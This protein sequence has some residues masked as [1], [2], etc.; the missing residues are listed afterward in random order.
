MFNFCK[1]SQY[2][3]KEKIEKNYQSIDFRYTGLPSTA[4]R[5][6]KYSL[7]QEFLIDKHCHHVACYLEMQGRIK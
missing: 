6:T 1:L 2:T 4:L 5:N 3:K 7:V